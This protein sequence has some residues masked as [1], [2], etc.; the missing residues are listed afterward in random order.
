MAAMVAMPRAES[1]PNLT[2]RFGACLATDAGVREQLSCLEEELDGAGSPKKPDIRYDPL[3]DPL[4][5]S[6]RHG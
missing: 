3:D 1:E 2:R 4:Y 6:P 5:V